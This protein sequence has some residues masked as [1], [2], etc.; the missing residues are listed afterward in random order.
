MGLSQNNCLPFSLPSGPTDILFPG[1]FFLEPFLPELLSL[2]SSGAFPVKSEATRKSLGYRNG[3]FFGFRVFFLLFFWKWWPC[4]ITHGHMVGHVNEFPLLRE[5]HACLRSPFGLDSQQ[6]RRGVSTPSD[7]LCQFLC[8]GQQHPC[9][10]QGY[11][12]ALGDKRVCSA[13][14]TMIK[15]FGRNNF[16][17]RTQYTVAED[18]PYLIIFQ[19]KG[20]FRRGQEDFLNVGFPN[21]SPPRFL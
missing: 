6:H 5:F 13:T 4:E 16:L 1:N 12:P 14:H 17:I 11:D 3:L 18:G 7:S 9:L 10:P 21:I 2:K 19:G 20:L 8:C 15:E